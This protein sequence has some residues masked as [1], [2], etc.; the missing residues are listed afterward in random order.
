MFKDKTS[1]LHK[2]LFVKELTESFFTTKIRKYLFG[3][4]A[5]FVRCLST[6]GLSLEVLNV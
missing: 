1:F 4:L 2:R 6:C 5:H 3:C